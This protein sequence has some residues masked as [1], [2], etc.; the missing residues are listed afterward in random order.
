MASL[1]RLLSQHVVNDQS[2]QIKDHTWFGYAY[3]VHATGLASLGHHINSSPTVPKALAKSASD[4]FAMACRWSSAL[5]PA[6]LAA[7]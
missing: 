1:L 7:S 4:M 2:C 3:L 5:K 6:R